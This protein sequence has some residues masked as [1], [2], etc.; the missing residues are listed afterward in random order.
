M[1]ALPVTTLETIEHLDFDHEE[2]CEYSQHARW[3]PED[4]P[5]DLLIHYRC[6]LCAHSKY[7]GMC[8][9]CYQ[10]APEHLHCVKCLKVDTKANSWRIVGALGAQS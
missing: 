7:M 2:S 1:N 5:A 4:A 8:R 9:P 6:S 3:T 10:R